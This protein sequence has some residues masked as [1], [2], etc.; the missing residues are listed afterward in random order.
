L[1][2]P[3]RELAKV[4]DSA[5]PAHEKKLKRVIYYKIQTKGRALKVDFK[6][7]A[8]NIIAYSDSDF[9][10][11]KDD[12][13]SIIGYIIFVSGS[14]ISWKSKSQPCVTLSSTE[15]EY[16]ALNETV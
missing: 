6:S 4:M 2:N 1:S 3:V 14:E 13:K 5:N 11:E 9:A 8:R 15:A 16:V 7:N 10:G 12:R